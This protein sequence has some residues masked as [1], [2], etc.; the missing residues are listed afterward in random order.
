MIVAVKSLIGGDDAFGSRTI[1]SG[2]NNGRQKTDDGYD[3]QEFDQGEAASLC[4]KSKVEN[5]K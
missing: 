2:Q 1:E 5:R 4:A 3:H